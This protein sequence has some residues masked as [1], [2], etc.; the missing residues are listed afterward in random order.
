MDSEFRSLLKQQTWS[1]VPPPANKNIVTYKQMFNLKWNSDGT[2]AKYKARLV[3]RGYLQQYGLDYDETFTPVVKFTTIRLLLALAM[4]CGWVLKQL[5]VGNAFLPSILKEEV[6][7]AQSQGYVDQSYLD[8]VCLLHK[9]SYGLKQ[10][11]QAQ[12]ER[13]STQLP[14]VD[15]VAS[16]VDFIYNHDDHIIFLLLYVDDIIVTSNHPNFIASLVA[17]LGQDFDLKDLGRLHYFLGL[18]IDYTP[19][20]LFVHQ[21]KYTLDLLHKCSMF[22]CKPCKTPYTPNVHPL[23]MK[24]LYCLIPLSIGVW[25]GLYNILLSLGVLYPLLCGELTS[26]YKCVANPPTRQNRPN[27]AWWV[28][29][30]YKIFFDNGSGWVQ[31]IKFQIRKTRPDSPIYF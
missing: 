20:E 31:A 10:A 4:N 8:H 28:G 2:I 11:P 26:S 16:G 15:F 3:A 25:W 9:A 18:Q 29:L 22:D 1:L 17:T 30:G 6:Y 14:H 13:F 12:F 21:T 24:I 7:M 23:P 27:P 5:D 19:V